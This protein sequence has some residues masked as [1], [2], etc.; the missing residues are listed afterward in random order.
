[1]VP[2]KLYLYPSIPRQCPRFFCQ[3]GLSESLVWHWQI[4][5]FLVLLLMPEIPFA[6]LHDSTQFPRT[7]SMT[8]SGFRA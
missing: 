4:P 8:A 5:G 1:M 6:F 7:I 3:P 2:V